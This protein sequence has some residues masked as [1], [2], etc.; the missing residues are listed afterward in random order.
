[1][2]QKPISIS[3]IV[4][5]TLA[6]ILILSLLAAISLTH[7]A[8][9]QM[10]TSLTLNVS[11]QEMKGPPTSDRLPVN[12]S[13]RLVEE[14]SSQN[15]VGGATITIYL[16]FGSPDRKLL[17]VTTDHDGSYNTH[18]DLDPGVHRIEADFAGDA[19]HEHSSRPA[20]LGVTVTCE[21]KTG[22]SLS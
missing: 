10:P 17:T 1:M 9:A 20:Q 11:K 13:G 6:G 5:V 19:Y 16:D 4:P 18:A 15:G 14:T 7:Q 21:L 3:A 8:F 12:I 2:M 22:C